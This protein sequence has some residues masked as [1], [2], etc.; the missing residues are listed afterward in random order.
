MDKKARGWSAKIVDTA[1]VWVVLQSKDTYGVSCKNYLENYQ[2][3]IRDMDKK[4]R[5]WSAKIV[6]TAQVRVV[7]QSQDTYGV[8]CKIDFY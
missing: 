8:S 4:A 5:G 3:A 7:R 2:K 6:E 1:H